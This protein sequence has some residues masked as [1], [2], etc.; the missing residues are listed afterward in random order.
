MQIV[1]MSDRVV[2]QNITLE[3]RRASG[4][5]V[6]KTAKESSHT[7]LLGQ[8]VAV[9]PGKT[10]EQG[11]LVPVNTRIGDVVLFGLYQCQ[12]IEVDGVNFILVRD[13]DIVGKIEG[14][15]LAERM[16]KVVEKQQVDT[17]LN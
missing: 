10:D 7:L 14:E 1:P 11:K 13:G 3:E 8:V 4:L 2:V 16:K 15:D 5:I 17:T 12:M 9:G 6:V